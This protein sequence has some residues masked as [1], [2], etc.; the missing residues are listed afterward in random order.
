[1]QTDFLKPYALCL[2]RLAQ[3]TPSS[4][5]YISSYIACAAYRNESSKAGTSQGQFRICLCTAI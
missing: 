3:I 5:A 1:M 4:T 2:I